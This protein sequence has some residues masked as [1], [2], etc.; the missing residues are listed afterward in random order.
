MLW[1]TTNT[2]SLCCVLHNNAT[3][4]Q[5]DEL[6]TCSEDAAPLRRPRCESLLDVFQAI[7]DDEVEHVRTMSA[8]QD[9]KK[10]RKGL[11]WVGR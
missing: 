2:G 10:A 5:F 7:R 1:Y 9:A 11:G 8:C 6:Q 4:L 3:L